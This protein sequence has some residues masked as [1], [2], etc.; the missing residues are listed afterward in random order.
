M[1]GIRGLALRPDH[2]F[3]DA[4]GGEE[5]IHVHLQ[6]QLTVSPQGRTLNGLFSVLGLETSAANRVL[7]I[8]SHRS[9]S[10]DISLA[11]VPS[12][13]RKAVGKMGFKGVPGIH[14][15]LTLSSPSRET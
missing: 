8:H 15:T 13:Q 10:R 11:E 9:Q 4:A 7:E 3:V 1:N 2:S 14:V 6:Q 12:V 5:Q